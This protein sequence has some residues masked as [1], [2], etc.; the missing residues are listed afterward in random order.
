MWVIARTLVFHQ[1]SFPVVVRKFDLSI[2]YP[3]WLVF[4]GHPGFLRHAKNRT[5]SHK[6]CHVILVPRCKG[7]SADNLLER[8]GIPQWRWYVTH[9][10]V[11]VII[12][13]FL[14]FTSTLFTMKLWPWESYWKSKETLKILSSKEMSNTEHFQCDFRVLEQQRKK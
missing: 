3:P 8:H 14:I 7:V 1:Y 13:F 11:I 5:P 4:S 2:P 6:F 9:D 10:P 12:I